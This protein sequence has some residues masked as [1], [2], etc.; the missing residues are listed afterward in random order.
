M[1]EMLKPIIKS[2]KADKGENGRY[3]KAYLE[4]II[5]EDK[6]ISGKC[7]KKCKFAVDLGKSYLYRVWNMGRKTLYICPAHG[8]ISIRQTEYRST[9]DGWKC[10]TEAI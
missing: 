10:R 9:P 4:V 8:I 5:P 1:T 3:K 7:A 6:Y 2:C